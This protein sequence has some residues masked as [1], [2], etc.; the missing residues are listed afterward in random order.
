[1]NTNKILLWLAGALVVAVVSL[2][3]I[4]LLQ[5]SEWRW[6]GGSYYAVYLDT[7][8]LYFGK[9]SR[10]P[11]LSISNVWYLQRD[12]QQQSL[13]ISDFSKVV[14]LP[15]NKIRIN[16]DKV[17]WT[18]KLTKDSPL[19]SSVKASQ[20]EASVPDDGSVFAPTTQTP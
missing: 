13:S 12:A 4:I 9:L 14:W 16:P 11:Y 20:Q 10:F 2:A 5:K 6:W 7:G 17:V 15:E 8:D 18:V 19:L 3:A 1:M